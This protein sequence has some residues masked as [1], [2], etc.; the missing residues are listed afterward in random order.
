MGRKTGLTPPQVSIYGKYY[1]IRI[2]DNGKRKRIRLCS[3]NA[4]LPTLWAAYDDFHKTTLTVTDIF[5][6]WLES[7]R[8]SELRPRTQ[9]DYIK[10]ANMLCR[11]Y[12]HFPPEKV[13]IQSFARYMKQRGLTSKRQ[14]NYERTV[15]IQCYKWARQYHVEIQT[16]PMQ[17]VLPFKLKPRKRYITDEE[18]YKVFQAASYSIK[19]AM[20]IAYL[21]AARLSDVINIKLNDVT[22]KGVYIQ[23]SKTGKEQLKLFSKRLKIAVERCIN[24]PKRF[25][26]E[27]LVLNDSGQK[28][29]VTGFESV[30][31]R[32]RK[33]VGIDFTFHDVK[34]K[35]I[36]DFEGDKREF[37]GHKS[38][39]MAEGYNVSVDEVM[40]LENKL[41]EW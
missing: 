20:E 7:E 25:K 23:Q 10:C 6:E 15:F 40:A 29:T 1:V 33:S 3:K 21:C 28:F 24:H 5:K 4:D 2:I 39:I 16:I 30:F 19:C 8:F 35:S 36:S 13:T 12:G 34:K 18:Y 14:A 11:V 38:A 9:S 32:L 37:S 22:D 26:S 27:Y 17:E 41:I 31:Y